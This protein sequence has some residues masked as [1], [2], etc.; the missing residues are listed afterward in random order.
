MIA[1]TR[2]GLAA[3]AFL[4]VLAPARS[5]AQP[6]WRPDR[7]LRLIVGF[8]PGGT[9]DAVARLA[10]AETAFV[11]PARAQVVVSGNDAKR[12]LVNGA[13]AVVPGPPPDT[14]SLVDLSREPF[15]VVDTAT[16]GTTVEGVMASPDGRHAVAGPITAPAARR[17]TRCAAARSC[18]S[19]AS[20]TA[21]CASSARRRW[22][23]GRRA[24]PSPATAAPC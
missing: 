15:R 16:V 9:A 13:A 22:A 20:R 21:G 3:A 18:G 8:A 7:P 1:I 4:P 12:A 24:W 23:T 6:S 5:G 2:R 10:A 19:S 17:A 14:V 11:P